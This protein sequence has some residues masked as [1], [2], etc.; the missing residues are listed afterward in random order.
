M[1]WLTNL[2]GIGIT[3]T[4]LVAASPSQVSFE[5]VPDGITPVTQ[6]QPTAP[7]RHRINVTVT[8]PEDIKVKQ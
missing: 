1:E 7:K 8:A 2:I 5:P 6:I 4:V 3:A